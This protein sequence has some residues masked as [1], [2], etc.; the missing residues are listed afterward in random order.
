MVATADAVYN[1]GR[2]DPAAAYEQ[3]ILDSAG[4]SKVDR[5]DV[6]I[7]AAFWGYVA[8][9]ETERVR[10]IEATLSEL[11]ANI[12][13]SDDI[14]LGLRVEPVSIK[15][16]LDERLEFAE[17]HSVAWWVAVLG[18]LKVVLQIAMGN[19]EAAERVIERVERAAGGNRTYSS[20]TACQRWVIHGMRGETDINSG[21]PSPIGA[22]T[23]R[24][25]RVV[26]ALD[27]MDSLSAGDRDGAERGFEEA[28]GDGPGSLALDYAYTATVGGL[29]KLAAGLGRAQE[30][31]EIDSILEPFDGQFLLELLQNI[32]GSVPFLRGLLACTT[33]DLDAGIAHFERAAEMEARNGLCALLVGTQVHLAEALIAAWRTR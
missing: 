18:F 32:S 9:P 33:G 13:R 16:L 2:S 21:A 7:N 19:L 12:L 29:A 30:A 5:V 1:P 4:L 6:L 15:A 17:R 31:R 20:I 23:R 3:L 22:L 25:P 8:S 26:H 28:W 24:F 10:Q 11:G 27:G 14:V